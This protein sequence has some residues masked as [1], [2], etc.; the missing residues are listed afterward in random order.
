MVSIIKTADASAIGHACD[1][2]RGGECVGIPTETVYGLAADA[3]N[4]EACRKIFEV[5]GRPLIDP[6]IV[7][8][9][10]RDHASSIAEVSSLAEK[11]MEHFWPGPLTLV[12]PRKNIV[13]DLVTSGLETVAVRSP[14]H[15]IMRMVIEKSGLFLA[16]PSANPFGYIS[17]TQAEHVVN[18][19][20]DRLKLV[21]DGG[22][23][24]H[25]VE[26]TIIELK[27]NTIHVLRP[28][29]IEPKEIESIIG[30]QVIMA[31]QHLPEGGGGLKSAGSLEKH[32]SPSTPC[33][34]VQSPA[35]GIKSQAS[36]WLQRPRDSDTGAN[37]SDENTFWLSEGGDHKE[38]LHNLYGLMHRLDQGAFT[39]IEI[40]SPENSDRFITLKDR[41]VRACQKSK[42]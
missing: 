24:D 38:M 37:T 13:P 14:S 7:H 26:S 41:L 11:I 28:G 20:G 5:K 6:L 10:N 22:P 31:A 40:Q 19:L 39:R 23:S 18:H 21:L 29:P 8:V 27:D 32:Y 3:L 4:P 30:Q 33:F 35:L 36:V 16:A 9:L 1:L 15:P 2:L 25:G 17:P 42:G 12:L 34:L